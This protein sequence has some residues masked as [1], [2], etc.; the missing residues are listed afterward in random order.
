MGYFL[1]QALAAAFAKGLAAGFAA[2]LVTG[3]V[4]TGFAV[5]LILLI[6]KRDS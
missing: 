5:S 4:C 2:G 6:R 3:A 1:H